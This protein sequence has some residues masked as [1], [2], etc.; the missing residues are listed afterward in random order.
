[1]KRVY[2]IFAALR[3]RFLPKFQ[4]QPTFRKPNVMQYLFYLGYIRPVQAAGLVHA[5]D[6]L[7]DIVA[8]T[9]KLCGVVLNIGMVY[10]DD[11]SVN[12]NLAYVGTHVAG[13]QQGHLFL[14]KSLFFLRHPDNNLNI[15]FSVLC[16]HSVKSSFVIII[17]G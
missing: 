11:I 9:L 12:R 4:K 17:T 1:M 14:D 7:I 2:L 16:C 10:I 5:L 8:Y 13:F 6:N 3:N 15:A